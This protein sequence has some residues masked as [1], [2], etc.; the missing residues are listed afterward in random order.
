MNREHMANMG[1]GTKAIHGG[2]VGD[3]QY[4]ALATPIYRTSTFIFDSAE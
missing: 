4:G 2:H 3:K 1:F